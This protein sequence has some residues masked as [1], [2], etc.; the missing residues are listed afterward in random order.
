MVISIHLM[1][2]VVMSLKIK[3]TLRVCELIDHE[4]IKW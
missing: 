2:Y 4:D 1:Y 3:V